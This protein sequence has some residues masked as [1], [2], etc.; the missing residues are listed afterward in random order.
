MRKWGTDEIEGESFA[1]SIDLTPPA[2]L[3]L[4]DLC[5][6]RGESLKSNDQAATPTG[7][8]KRVF[9]RSSRKPLAT[10]MYS[11]RSRYR[12]GFTSQHISAG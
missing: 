5:V 7:L 4:C 11:L 8:A 1:Q 9:D 12:P 2:S 10:H 6:L 3:L